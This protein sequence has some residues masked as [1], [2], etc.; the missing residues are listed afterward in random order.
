MKRL[1]ISSIPVPQQ[2]ASGRNEDAAGRGTRD[3]GRHAKYYI[4]TR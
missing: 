3:G 4:N 2:T 1:I